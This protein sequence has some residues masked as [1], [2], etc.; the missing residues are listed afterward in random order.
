MSIVNNS[1]NVSKQFSTDSN[2]AFRIDFYSKY[3]TAPQKFSDWLF[4]KYRFS[5]NDTI[6][7]LGCG[8]GCHWDNRIDTLPSGCELILSD[9]SE[10]MINEVQKKYGDKGVTIKKIDIQSIPYDSDSIDVIIANHMLFH[11]PDLSKALSEICRVLRTDGLFYAATDSD[12]GIRPYLHD[13]LTRFDS[14][15]K[16]FTEKFSFS[17]ENGMEILQDF[18]TSVHKFEYDFPLSV[19]DT[20]DLMKW[21]VSTTDI[22]GYAAECY[23]EL[24]S[25]FE[26]IRKKEGTIIIPKKSGIFVC[27]K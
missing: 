4:K 22:S 17:L 24:Y 3:D 2:L 25:Y 7:E 10:G 27:S 18:F 23:D 19:V 11:I 15:N 1:E 26:N 6:L 21:L 8:N 12:E 14:S 20:N 16:A 13:V 9:I 5:E